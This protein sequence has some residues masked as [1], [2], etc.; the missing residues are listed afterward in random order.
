MG[1][2][3]LF[4]LVTIAGILYYVYD[5]HNSKEDRKGILIP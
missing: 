5:M 4:G 2:M 1:L 3:I